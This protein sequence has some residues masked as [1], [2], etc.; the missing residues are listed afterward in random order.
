MN[1]LVWKATIG[2]LLHDV[3]KIIYR[4][5][6][7]SRSHPISGRD[8]IEKY[9]GDEELLQCIAFHH[10]ASLENAKIA[11]SNPAYAVYIA[12]NIASGT[13]RRVCEG[14]QIFGFDK[15]TALDSIFNL[16]CN[17]QQKQK[18]PLT[19]IRAE[20]PRATNDIQ[21]RAEQYSKI[22]SQLEDGLAGISLDPVYV[23]SLLELM[24]ACLSYVPSST[25]QEEVPD[26]S[27]FDHQKITAAVA[28]CIIAYCQEN[29]IHDLRTALLKEEKQF[30]TREV[31]CLCSADLSGIQN[32]IYRVATKSALKNLRSRSF[33][34]ELL[35]ENTADE[36]LSAC[37]LTRAN[38]L[39]TGG[40]HAY[41]LLPNTQ[42]AKVAFQETLRNLNQG[43]QDYFG[44]LLF[45]AFG[46]Q[47]CSANVLMSQVHDV[48]EA[49][50]R[51]FQTVS[52][53]VSRQ[54]LHR[55]DATTLMLFNKQDKVSG[56]RECSICGQIMADSQEAFCPN[57]RR[58]VDSSKALLEKEA[59]FVVSRD[60]DTQSSLPLWD[61]QGEKLWLKITDQIHARELLV[62]EE[63]LVHRLY[64][65]NI[66][67]TGYA[68]ASKLWMG[69]YAA[70]NPEGNI[71]AFE[72]MAK[73]SEG[74]A[75]IAVLRMDVDNLG[76]AFTHGF[77]RTTGEN[78]YQ[79]LTLSRTASFSRN[80]S[81]FFKYY[82]NDIL[83]NGRFQFR[84]EARKGSSCLVYS[85]GDDLFLVGAWDEV[86]S[87]AID[88]QEA[89]EAFSGGVLTLSA[90]LAVFPQSYPLAAMARETGD[91]EQLSKAFSCDGQSKNAISLFGLERNE[92]GSVL[93]CKHTYSW[94]VLRQQI[95]EEKMR[96]L[97]R[98]LEARIDLGHSFLYKLISL[99]GGAVDQQRLNVARL[100]YLLAR[101]EDD[102]ADEPAKAIYR[103]FTAKAYTWALNV[104][105][106]Q[107]LVTALMILIYT[108]RGE[109]EEQE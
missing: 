8:M 26:I 47:P 5:G 17:S 40:G 33:Y 11:S 28:A 1:S 88:I 13:D 78:P 62:R 51:L 39:Y 75:R 70:R 24:E 94:Q 57:C 31:F 61:A 10:K 71:A 2:G 87:A 21:T 79:Y 74:I 20:F 67:R 50:S 15:Y 29:G 85:G 16:L 101:R 81:M 41:W 27:L 59:V 80:L 53:Q 82:I 42:Q 109:K 103:E 105:D 23:N 25:N 37:G 86:F 6:K 60:A 66:F 98:L 64:S 89:F 104:K 34:L 72:E 9:T 73:D 3:G 107:Q 46:F 19:E 102:R 95:I 44:T 91:L 55:Y 43:L 97:E 22:L 76:V 77:I 99:L 35:I 7:D 45:I 92:T 38:L 12:D 90:G 4:S 63:G 32:F 83:A 48:P 30:Y 58:F 52:K 54:K 69:D 100:A 106:R 96:I 108:R 18:L 14:E 93:I 56:E 68:M 84:E 49:Y 65:K 36:V